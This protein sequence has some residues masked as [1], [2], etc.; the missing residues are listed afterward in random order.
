MHGHVVSSPVSVALALLL[1]APAG[2]AVR[3]SQSPLDIGI[4][5]EVSKARLLQALQ[6]LGSSRYKFVLAED[7][8]WIGINEPGASTNL[9]VQLLS[10]M[11]SGASQEA[12]AQR[13][14]L[15]SAM[16][17]VF[18][19]PGQYSL[20]GSATHIRA[21]V[22]NSVELSIER[23]DEDSTDSWAA[24]AGKMHT[25]A[26]DLQYD[27]DNLQLRAVP[28][29]E[30]SAIRN[31]AYIVQP[32]RITRNNLVWWQKFDWRYDV[33]P[34]STTAFVKVQGT[35][36]GPYSLVGFDT[37]SGLPSV[38]SFHQDAGNCRVLA[39]YLYGSIEGDRSQEWLKAVYR[40][41]R[42]SRGIQLRRCRMDA[43]TFDVTADDLLLSIE[44]GVH[45]FDERSGM[46]AYFGPERDKWPPEILRHLRFVDTGL[47]QSIYPVPS[48]RSRH[49]PKAWL[50]Q[51]PL[52]FLGLGLICVGG[53]CVFHSR[54]RGPRS[55]KRGLAGLS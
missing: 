45:L 53:V 37:L 26:F 2:W 46:Q 51:S 48:G 11:D 9:L 24:I 41:V 17:E 22:V 3:D 4:D 7:R 25:P 27:R 35:P 38:A 30:A 29:D 50:R 33:S 49:L 52:T 19:N 47:A 13:A 10:A 16:D 42:N 39:L 23:R 14:A 32:L 43:V 31:P 20:P 6:A 1:A 36:S 5:N 12:F 55:R 28:V 34:T 40:I 8:V 54:K 44:Q 18:A 15:S 21:I